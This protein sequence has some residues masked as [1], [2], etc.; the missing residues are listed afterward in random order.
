MK[1]NNKK[2]DEIENIEKPTSAFA[3][4]TKLFDGTKE[5]V[6][7]KKYLEDPKIKPL[8]LSQKEFEMFYPQIVAMIE[9]DDL[10]MQRQPDNTLHFFHKI[11]KDNAKNWVCKMY[12]EKFSALRI[13]KEYFGATKNKNKITYINKFLHQKSNE[14]NNA[15]YYSADPKDQDLFIAYANQLVDNDKIVAFIDAEII[16]R[17]IKKKESVNELFD[18]AEHADIV[19][20]INIRD[21]ESPA[22]YTEYITP[23]LRNRRRDDLPVIFFS[24]LSMIELSRRLERK[25]KYNDFGVKDFINTILICIEKVE[26]KLS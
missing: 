11:Q 1:V 24:D 23:L 16:Y 9:S 12:P 26:I 14:I 19:F 18:E 6:Y 22:I 5:I 13:T 17:T 7:N 10:I 15:W 4:L 2:N 8:N 25:Y 21:F 20:I 3:M